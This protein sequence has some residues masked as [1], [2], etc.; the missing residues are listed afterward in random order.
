MSSFTCTSFAVP[1]Y[2]MTTRGADGSEKKSVPHQQCCVSTTPPCSFPQ[3]G[4]MDADWG[5]SQPASGPGSAVVKSRPCV[6]LDLLH[7]RQRPSQVWETNLETQIPSPHTPQDEGSRGQMSG[8][9]TAHSAGKQ[10]VE[11]SMSH[12]VTHK[13]EKSLTWRPPWLFLD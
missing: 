9:P 12:A 3:R 7:D 13:M 4:C 11:M 6:D 2:H 5:A 10:K 1:T 8:N